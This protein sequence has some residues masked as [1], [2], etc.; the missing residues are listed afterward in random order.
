MLS[1]ADRLDGCG[2]RLWTGRIRAGQFPRVAY[3]IVCVTAF[4][5]AA[6]TLLSGFGLGTLLMPA[7]ALF[8]PVPVAIAATAVV[9]L[10]NN[11]FKLLLVGRHADPKVVLRFAPPAAVA[12][13]LGASLLSTIAV[14]PPLTTYALAGRTHEITVVKLAVATLMLG[15][16]GLE[17]HPRFERLAFDRRWLSLGGFLS[18]FFGGLSGHQGPLRAAFLV[19]A[20]LDRDAFIGTSV[21]SAVVVDVARLI[22]YGAGMPAAFEPRTFRLVAAATVAAFAGSFAGARLA[23]VVGMRSIQRLVGVLLAVFA[24]AMAVGLI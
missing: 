4:G 8:F 18:G 2:R 14:V 16:A 10:A 7:F 6:L 3:A 9:H 5:V 12:A 20:G 21:V 15:F 11:L 13:V 22:V 17:L 24:L 23:R 19:N 1:E